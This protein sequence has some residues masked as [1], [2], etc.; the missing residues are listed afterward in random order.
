M[1][2]LCRAPGWVVLRL[3]SYAKPL[4]VGLTRLSHQKPCL[5]LS[6]L[7]KSRWSRSGAAYLVGY[8][9]C[10]AFL[11]PLMDFIG[12]FLTS[13]LA[14][15]GFAIAHLLF[16]LLFSQCRHEYCHRTACQTCSLSLSSVSDS[17]K[18]RQF[19]PARRHA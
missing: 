3:L 10:L 4:S 1:L 9:A 8:L 7:E 19:Y 13:F 2:R 18:G 14:S 16:E 17:D 5:S 6:Q 11:S 15:L 12:F